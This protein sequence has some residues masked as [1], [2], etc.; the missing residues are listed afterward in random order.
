MLYSSFGTP[1]LLP[2]IL[3][4]LT[5][6]CDVPAIVALGTKA[7]TMFFT[8]TI[9]V[10]CGGPLAVAIMGGIWPETVRGDE[11]WRGLAFVAGEWIGGGSNGNAMIEIFNPTPDVLSQSIALDVI[12]GNLWMMC[13]LLMIGQ[14]E[15]V[16][17]W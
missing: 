13:L 11:V 5:A 2:A 10:V 17:R 8:G 9:G 14:R 3:I 16:D 15:R 7:L 12:W 1:I 4:L 6:A